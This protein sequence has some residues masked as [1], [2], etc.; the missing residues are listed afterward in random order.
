[1]NTWQRVAEN[2]AGHES[3]TIYLRAAVAGKPIRSS[4]KTTDLA[5]ARRKSD[6]EI[7]A[8][9]VTGKIEVRDGGLGLRCKRQRR[10]ALGRRG[11]S[12]AAASRC[13]ARHG[14]PTA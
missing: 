6:Q 7:I 8:A 4:L 9:A 10:T 3:A 12:T 5:A 1:M 13:M 11:G 2:L 14:P